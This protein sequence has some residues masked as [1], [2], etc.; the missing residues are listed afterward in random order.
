MVDMK[1]QMFGYNPQELNLLTARNIAIQV[2]CH[3]QEL[4]EQACWQEWFQL[5]AV[6]IHPQEL[7]NLSHNISVCLENNTELKSGEVI[8]V[9]R[10]VLCT[11][12]V[13]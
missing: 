5:S 13:F 3:K 1:V 2:V 9:S 6:F 7:E 11:S 10:S 12:V 4:N 8:N